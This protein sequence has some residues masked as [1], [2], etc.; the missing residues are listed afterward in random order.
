MSL[1]IGTDRATP[2]SWA[3]REDSNAT[4]VNGT[5]TDPAATF[6]SGAAY[7]FVRDGTNWT[8]Q[9]YLKSTNPGELSDNFGA[10]VG[11]S[12][13][14]V[15]VGVRGDS[16]NGTGVNAGFNPGTAAGSGASYVFSGLGLGRRLT[17]V[18][19]GSAGYLLRFDGAPEVTYRM[20][21]ASEVLGPWDAIGTVTAPLSGLVEY[22]DMTLPPGQAFYR[23]LQR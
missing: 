8:Q 23:T 20:E 5:G 1:Q 12:G 13:D 16:S 3:L 7:V 11:L 14:T 4:G 15:V 19:E 6:D 17:I 22:L 9:A 21:R 10:T 18:R 2:S